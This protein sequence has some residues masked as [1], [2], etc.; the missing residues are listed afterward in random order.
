MSTSLFLWIVAI[1][2]WIIMITPSLA[3]LLTGWISSRDRLLNFLAGDALRA[4]YDLFDPVHHF[5]TNHGY[6]THFRRRFNKRYGRRNYVVPIALLAVTA[7]LGLWAVAETTRTWMGAGRGAVNL[8]PIAVSAILGAYLWVVWDQ[9][10]RLR[11]RDFTIHDI[12]GCSFRLMIAVPMGVSLAVVFRDTA[13]PPLAFFLGA[14]PT[15]TLFKIIRRNVG[16]KFGV[17]TGERGPTELI[18]LQGTSLETVERFQEEGITTNSQLAWTE[19]VDLAIRTNFNLDYVIDCQS[20]ALLWTYFEDQ[21]RKLFPFMI[22]G[23][24]EVA[25][26]MGKP[27]DGGPKVEI[28][29]AETLA[30]AAAA[31]G[32]P[33]DVFAESLLEVARDPYNQILCAMWYPQWLPDRPDE[34]S[35]AAEHTPR[36]TVGHRDEVTITTHQTRVDAR[37]GAKAPVTTSKTG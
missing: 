17:D 15:Q 26:M 25:E 30:A 32:M 24:M 4:Y 8:P 3:Y 37:P 34:E 14:F 13:G 9:L 33:R 6:E 36:T 5:K 18:K 27:R 22:R 1:V 12:Y 2:A 20:Q 35:D 28:A 19:P 16:Q 11:N 7:G 23:A 10:T 29:P 21:T 31:I